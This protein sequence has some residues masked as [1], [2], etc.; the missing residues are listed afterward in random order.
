MTEWDLIE[1]LVVISGLFLTIGR[2][3]LQHNQTTTRILDR[4]EHQEHEIQGNAQVIDKHETRL[5]EHEIRI[6]D[7][8]GKERV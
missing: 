1:V 4:L 2:P 7:L 3:I 5:H 8:E 6:H